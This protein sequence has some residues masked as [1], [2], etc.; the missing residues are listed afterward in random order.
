MATINYPRLP[1]VCLK[2]PVTRHTI[3]NNE[4]SYEK[5]ICEKNMQLT[6][7]NS[8]IHQQH[9]KV[10]RYSGSFICKETI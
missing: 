6:D 5:T 9:C 2:K 10:S 4:S 3:S 1:H 7:F 8:T